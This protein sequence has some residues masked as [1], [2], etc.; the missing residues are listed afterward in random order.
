MGYAG[1]LSLITKILPFF[2]AW[3]LTEGF[4]P[5]STPVLVVGAAMAVLVY[6]QGKAVGKDVGEKVDKKVEEVLHQRVR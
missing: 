2:G 6:L 3:L 4:G 5:T 1:I